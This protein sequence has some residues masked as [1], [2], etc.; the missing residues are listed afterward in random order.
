MKKLLII[1]GP[2]GA[3]KNYIERELVELSPIGNY[4]FKKL[5]QVTTRKRRNDEDP[6]TFVSKE[7][8]KELESK[9]IAKSV[10]VDS[11]GETNYYGTKPEF[12]DDDNVIHTVIANR[13]GIDD[14]LKYI[15]ESDE[16]I[17]KFVLMIDSSNPK[18]RENRDLE[19]IVEERR[20]LNEVFDS[21]LINFPEQDSYITVDEVFECLEANEFI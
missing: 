15:D 16:E 12:S 10:I 1:C 9:L 6:Y 17:K 8:Y 20:K 7:E 18:T 13:K 2:S 5:E 11:E 21:F 19:F 3:G 14:L 4:T